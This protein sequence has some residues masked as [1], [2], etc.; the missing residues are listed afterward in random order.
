ML[1]FNFSYDTGDRMPG[2]W[3]VTLQDANPASQPFHSTLILDTV[4]EV[5][6]GSGEVGV[7]DQVVMYV[8]LPFG[9]NAPVEIRVT[10]QAVSF[11]EKVHLDA[12][13]DA[14]LGATSV[15]KDARLTVTRATF[16]KTDVYNV[17]QQTKEITFKI[18]KSH[19]GT[20]S[21]VKVER[22]NFRV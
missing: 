20:G 19:S 6:R 15:Q 11:P 2:T 16:D 5:S 22:R 1:I 7:G 8:P 10:G 3:R 17:V 4:N 14:L 13:I 21:K 12:E 18:T 9:A